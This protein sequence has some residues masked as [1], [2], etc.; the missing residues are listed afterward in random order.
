MSA[1]QQQIDEINKQLEEMNQLVQARPE[2]AQTYRSLIDRYT[3]R[4]QELESRMGSP[5]A[6]TLGLKPEA[7]PI[8]E[9]AP[10]PVVEEEPSKYSKATQEIQARTG[11]KGIGPVSELKDYTTMLADA[12]GVR[13]IDGTKAAASE[14]TADKAKVEDKK[15]SDTFSG[16]NA[17]LSKKRTAQEEDT[18]PAKALEEKQKLEEKL[19][20][21]ERG[22]LWDLIGRK[23]GQFGAAQGG[24]DISKEVAEPTL[25]W[26]S[27]RKEAREDYDRAIRDLDELRKAKAEARKEGRTQDQTDIENEFKRTTLKLQ[28][29]K[30]ELDAAEQAARDAER[31]DERAQRTLLS[32]VKQGRAA[33]VKNLDTD[34][35]ELKNKDRQLQNLLKNVDKIEDENTSEADRKVWMNQYQE[36]TGSPYQ[37]GEDGTLAWLG[38]TLKGS[39]VPTSEEAR[40]QNLTK[41]QELSQKTRE[42][43]ERVKEQQQAVRAGDYDDE[44]ADKLRPRVKGE[45]VGATKQQ[46]TTAAP[47]EKKQAPLVSEEEISKFVQLNPNVNRDKAKAI[48]TQRKSKAGGM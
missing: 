21:T 18:T 11:T 28:E 10:K 32:D 14:T 37:K 43:Y 7:K 13:G 3:K 2:Q 24:V 39:K 17:L 12:S 23:L 48:L 36:L 22:E 46:A 19:A 6:N 1:Y 33:L 29:K 9:P 35:N 38:R 26:K 47:V 16:L 41:L 45:Q 34:K 15:E 5:V 44:I 25:D 20:G 8:T 4:K 42:E 27:M 40:E 31:K 30:Q